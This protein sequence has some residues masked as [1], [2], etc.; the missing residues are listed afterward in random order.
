M[1]QALGQ[2]TIINVSDG[3]KGDAGASV[4]TLVTTYSGSQSTLE[5]WG[6]SG[7][8]SWAFSCITSDYSA[9]KVGDT[10]YMRCTNTTKGGYTFVVVKIGSIN[11]S[12]FAASTGFGIV[13]K[14]NTGETGPQGPKGDTGATGATGPQGPKGDMGATGA[15]GPQGPK[16]DNY[17]ITDL[18]LDLSD[19]AKYADTTWYPVVGTSLPQTGTARTKITVQLNSGTKPSWST[20]TSGFSVDLDVQDQRSGWGTTESKCLIYLDNYRFATANPASYGQMSYGSLPVLY[21]RGGGKYRVMTDYA[22]TWSIKTETYTWTSGSYSQSVSPQ[23]SR[24]APKG[25][26]IQGKDGNDG[27][28]AEAVVQYALVRD[29]ESVS[30][31]TWSEMVPEFLVGYSYWRRV[32]TIW[33]DGRADTY[34]TPQR[35]DVLTGAMKGYAQFTF[36]MS[37]TTYTRNL[38][39][40]SDST[41]VQ[42]SPRISGYGTILPVFT[43]DGMDLDSSTY[44]IPF[45][46]ERLS[47][48]ISMKAEYLGSVLVA[49]AQELKCIDETVPAFYLGAHASAPT[50]AGGM[51]LMKGDWYFST[52]SKKTYVYTAS[53]TWKVIEAGDEN[54]AEMALSTLPDKFEASVGVADE[55]LAEN[56]YVKNLISTFVTAAYIAAKDIEL[57]E[58]GTVRSKGYQKGTVKKLINGESLPSGTPEKG[59]HMDT[60]GDAEFYRADMYEVNV[61]KGNLSDV[62]VS[63]EL[64]SETFTTQKED[65]LASQH[66]NVPITEG[67]GYWDEASAVASLSSYSSAAVQ[68]LTGSYA[69]TSFSKAIKLSEAERTERRYLIDTYANGSSTAV[70]PAAKLAVRFEGTPGEYSYTSINGARVLE[71]SLEYYDG[72]AWKAFTSSVTVDVAPGKTVGMRGVMPDVPDDALLFRTRV[73]ALTETGIYGHVIATPYY[74]SQGCSCIL[75]TDDGMHRICFNEGATQATTYNEPASPY[76]GAYSGSAFGNRRFVT[77]DALSTIRTMVSYYGNNPQAYTASLGDSS[78]TWRTILF[79]D[80]FFYAFSYSNSSGAIAH[81][82]RSEYG[83]SW[84]ELPNSSFGLKSTMRDFVQV[85]SYLYAM[86]G[87]S[88]VRT[89][90]LGY[91]ET[92]ATFS[93][94]TPSRAHLSYAESTFF[95]ADGSVLIASKDGSAWYTPDD[96]ANILSVLPLSGPICLRQKV[97]GYEDYT[98]CMKAAKM[99]QSDFTIKYSA[100]RKKRV[101]YDWSSMSEG[102]NFIDS[103]GAKVGFISVSAPQMVPK[104]TAFSIASGASTLFSSSSATLWYRYRGLRKKSGSSY[105]TIA[106]GIIGKIDSA[107]SS[108]FTYTRKGESAKSVAASAIKS[109]AWDSSGLSVATSSGTLNFS[110]SDWFSAFSLAVTPVGRSRGNYTEGIFPESGEDERTSD[111]DLGSIDNRFSNVYAASFHGPLDGTSNLAKKAVASQAVIDSDNGAYITASTN[112]ASLTSS[113]DKVLSLSGN[114]IRTVATALL[115]VLEAASLKGFS[116]LSS[117]TWGVQTGTFVHGEGVDG[118]DWGFRKNCPASGQISLMVDGRFYQNEGKYACID[119]SGGTINGTLT[120]T[121]VYGAVWQ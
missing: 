11:L 77:L 74:T 65:V 92:L 46:E 51:N 94:S 32:R 22:A 103:S 82:A 111:I 70:T 8:G 87:S 23:T 6:V 98:C 18:W 109:L 114:E 30:S 84:T 99:T 121:T 78:S 102:W 47:I 24:P 31:A 50:D 57:Q 60:S 13:D 17:W 117:Q 116:A 112:K 54:F 88:V 80:G 45:S 25:T 105:V 107:S 52:S 108:A 96:Y 120:A 55:L 12:A 44:T 63:G 81:I 79:M 19:T 56:I 72:S 97:S 27:A 41:A 37:R 110:T 106:S 58:G 73:N 69:G 26:S 33:S 21:L 64:K 71:G 40:R 101:S 104:T 48:R 10:C 39:N 91:F 7:G 53:D 3:A 4:H 66:S 90:N 67:T 75:A 34:S 9:V 5:S 36:Q 28:S 85:G 20:H 16:G 61:S 118:C 95:I 100:S 119:T 86:D 38:R 89:P 1:A 83:T 76:Q 115:K 49:D 93:F 62:T 59:F 68:S 2:Y 15:T 35:D 29:G 43:A 14:G 113:P 42:F